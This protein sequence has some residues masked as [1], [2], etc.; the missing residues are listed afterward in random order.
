[1]AATQ[2]ALAGTIVTA[3]ACATILILRGAP[4]WGS[5]SLLVFA[6]VGLLLLGGADLRS[7][8]GSRRKADRTR[9]GNSQA[10]RNL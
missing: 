9:D 3:L 2:L 8:A 7:K 1:M 5:I 4:N 6:V 10:E